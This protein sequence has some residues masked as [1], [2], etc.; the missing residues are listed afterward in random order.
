MRVIFSQHALRR[1]A[2]RAIPRAWVEGAIAAPDWTTPDP[3]DPGLTRAYKSVPEA[4]GQIL[5]VVY[6]RT[7]EDHVFVVTAFPD[8]DAVSPVESE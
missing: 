2:E 5:R 4:G 6:S 7:S 8:R 1:L 3:N